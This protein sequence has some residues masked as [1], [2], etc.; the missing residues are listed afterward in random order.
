MGF[1]NKTYSVIFDSKEGAIRQR[2]GLTKKDARFM[3]NDII[4]RTKMVKAFRIS[5]V[6][7]VKER[8]K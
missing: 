3:A 8:R 4:S 5:N 1:F 7:V 6:R 2:K